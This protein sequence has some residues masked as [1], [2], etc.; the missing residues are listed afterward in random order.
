MKPRAVAVPSADP[1]PLRSALHRAYHDADYRKTFEDERY[2]YAFPLEGEVQLL[3][4]VANRS[5]RDF[6]ANS[7][8]FSG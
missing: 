2:R 5:C 7:E 6:S 8:S 1:V 3:S 4:N